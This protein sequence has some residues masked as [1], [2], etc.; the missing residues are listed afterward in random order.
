MITF[1]DCETTTITRNNKR[2]PSPLNPGNRLV[3]VGWDQNGVSDYL[4]F[5]HNHEPPSDRG[6]ERLQ[7]ILSAT[8]LLVAHH[9]KFDIS[10]M[11][12]CGFAYTGDLHCTM[13]AEYVMAA[14]VSV[15]LGLEDTCARYGIKDTKDARAKELWASGVGYEDMPWDIVRDYGSQDVNLLKQLYYAQ[16]KRL[17][18]LIEEIRNDN[19]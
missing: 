8:T 1:L 9:L 14:G 7:E 11:W 19:S 4:C 6:S 13:I 5:N 3:S 17:E 12:E 10:W 2:D 16:Q 18:V 15:S